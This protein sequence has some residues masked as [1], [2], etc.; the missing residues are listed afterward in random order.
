MDY[1]GISELRCRALLIIA[2]REYSVSQGKIGQTT[3]VR[4]H[5]V[6]CSN[7]GFKVG[8]NFSDILYMFTSSWF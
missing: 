8:N 2:E 1:N 3:L 4:E 6:I 7:E 5:Q